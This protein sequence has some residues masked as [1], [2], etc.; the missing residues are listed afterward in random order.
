MER[1]A[2]LIEATG[3]RISCLLNPNTLLFQRRA[4]LRARSSLGGALTGVGLADAPLFHDGGG[5]TELTL[6]LLFDSTLSHA[7]PRDAEADNDTLED[8]R[9][10]TRPLWQLAENP[11]QHGQLS[12]VRFVWGKAWNYPSYVAAVAERLEDFLPSGVPRRSYLRLRLVRA[13]DRPVPRATPV[14]SPVSEDA[15]GLE[16][17]PEPDEDAGPRPGDPWEPAPSPLS[18]EY[19]MSLGEPLFLTAFSLWGDPARWRILADANPDL[20]PLFVPPG[21]LLRVP[22]APSPDGRP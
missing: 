20:D 6:D 11:V 5:S 4:G 19:H 10:L 15:L 12:R 3:E 16:L 22:P 2:F 7:A 9:N 13:E 1:A 8:V 14:A 18:Y 17:S 21:Q